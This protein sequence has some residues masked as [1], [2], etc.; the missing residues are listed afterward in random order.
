MRPEKVQRRYRPDCPL[1]LY[2]T[3]EPVRALG[4][5]NTDPDRKLNLAV[6][7]RAPS[8]YSVRLHNHFEYAGA[9]SRKSGAVHSDRWRV[10]GRASRS[11]RRRVYKGPKWLTQESVRT[12]YEMTLF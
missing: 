8:P 1:N 12:S 10:A 9:H 11:S 6:R 7:L 3:H 2:Q 5:L 4:K